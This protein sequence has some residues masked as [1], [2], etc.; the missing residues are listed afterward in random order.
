M[1]DR[2]AATHLQ[3]PTP[4]SRDDK[5]IL[6]DQAAIAAELKRTAGQATRYEP[7]TNREAGGSA[8]D[9]SAAARPSGSVAPQ[10]PIATATF[11]QESNQPVNRFTLTDVLGE[12]GQGQVCRAFDN[13]LQRHVAIKFP[14][15]T[16]GSDAH[17]ILEE[18]RKA[19]RLNHPNVV[20]IYECGM[21]QGRP[22]ICM[23]FVD[24]TSLASILR[25]TGRVS[26]STFVRYSTQILKALEAAHGNGL[27]HRDLK[28]ANVLQ[29]ND[30]TLKLTDFGIAHLA[31]AKREVDQKTGMIMV[32][33]T[34]AYM[35]PEVWRGK[36][37]DKR[38]DIYAFG[39]MAYELLTGKQP[40]SSKDA[41]Q[42]HLAVTPQPIRQLVPSVPLS[43]ERIVMRC[44]EKNPG[45]RFADTQGVREAIESAARAD[46]I[47]ETN[48]VPAPKK[49]SSALVAIM[50][51]LIVAGV[52]GFFGFHPNG[53]EL[54]RRW[55]G[56]PA[57][58]PIE[59]KDTEKTSGSA[60]LDSV[61]RKG[62]DLL[63][64]AIAAPDPDR[65]REL[66]Q[67]ASEALSGEDRAQALAL[68]DSAERA[69]AARSAEQTAADFDASLAEIKT[70][71]ASGNAR[72][73]LERLLSV[74]KNVDQSANLASKKD[75]VA[76]L[77]EKVHAGHGTWLSDNGDFRSAAKS[78]A[79][80]AGA[81]AI[82]GR[83]S[84]V[85]DLQTMSRFNEELA[86]LSTTITRQPHFV[87]VRL[88]QLEA[89]RKT[90][91]IGTLL[92]KAVAEAGLG[93]FQ[94]AKATLKEIET[95]AAADPEL[96]AKAQALLANL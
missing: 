39:C 60:A 70:V 38:S 19:A 43:F 1:A 6:T 72:S 16:G 54:W 2:N 29:A 7:A 75:S 87:L 61:R 67:K 86:N 44:L 64:E 3:R 50:L 85:M 81:A 80:A 96:K 18:A 12:G 28:P 20:T 68:V 58:A 90:L 14:R 33:G 94:S 22:F 95:A 82:L 55:T 30:G 8:Y 69:I 5:T 56:T 92:L 27:V 65:K 84:E 73:A 52:S 10:Q 78:F 79:E 32:A 71:L 41:F 91:P 15:Q 77:A 66:A 74:Q 53:K 42:Q 31:G 93:R 88:R 13:H 21:W 62:Q 51:V 76:E 4:P 46:Q 63:A 17:E 25:E 47:S 89:E 9:P 59:K 11:T 48:F 83:T 35:A 26:P 45:D 49:S 37:P 36:T 34:P 24:G 40:F 57:Q 23:E